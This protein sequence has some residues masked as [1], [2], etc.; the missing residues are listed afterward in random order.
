MQGLAVK[1]AGVEQFNSDDLKIIVKP[2]H[3][4]AIN[5]YESAHTSLENVPQEP[6]VQNAEMATIDTNVNVIGVGQLANM[7]SMASVNQQLKKGN[8]QSAKKSSALN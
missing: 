6:V 7:G 5:N 3:T 1:L 4:H 2:R 8:A